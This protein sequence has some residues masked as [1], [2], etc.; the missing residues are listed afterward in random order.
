MSIKQLTK[1]NIAWC[2]T[3]GLSVRPS[4]YWRR[5]KNHRAIVN[6]PYIQNK[7]FSKLFITQIF[8]ESTGSIASTRTLAT[9]LQ[10]ILCVWRSKIVHFKRF[11]LNVLFK[12]CPNCS[13]R[14]KAYDLVFPGIVQSFNSF[15]LWNVL[16]LILLPVKNT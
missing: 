5:Q 15:P 2:L 16:S 7:P 12:S 9:S 8:T 4:Y 13:C 10:Y 1:E 3:A 11:Y 14:F 6:Y